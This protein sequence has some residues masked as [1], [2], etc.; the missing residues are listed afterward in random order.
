MKRRPVECAWPVVPTS[1]T[2]LICV[3]ITDRPIA[4]HGS[5]RLPKVAFDLV[6]PFRAAQAVVDDPRHVDDDDGPVERSHLEL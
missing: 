6:R 5:D 1:V 4:H 2:A 3:A